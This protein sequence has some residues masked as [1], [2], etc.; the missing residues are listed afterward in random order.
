[1]SQIILAIRKIQKLLNQQDSVVY[2]ISLPKDWVEKNDIEKGDK[3]AW[4]L[5][6][7]NPEKLVLK[8]PE[9]W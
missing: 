7:D 3:L 8:K 9:E 2:L 6:T 4:E 1:M 5:D